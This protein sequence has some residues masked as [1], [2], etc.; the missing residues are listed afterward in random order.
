MSEHVSKDVSGNIMLGT[1]YRDLL[2][3]T[4]DG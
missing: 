1:V 3:K 4:R 2:L